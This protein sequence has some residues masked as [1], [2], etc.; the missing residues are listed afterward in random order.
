MTG[1]LRPILRGSCF[2]LAAILLAPVTAAAAE[3]D[4]DYDAATLTR[5]PLPFPSGTVATTF[6]SWTGTAFPYGMGTFRVGTTGEYSLAVSGI[7]G[8]V[9]IFVI[10][11]PFAPD[12]AAD[13]VTPLENVLAGTQAPATIPSIVLEAGV[14]Y[15]WLVVV[16]SGS[17]SGTVAIEGGCVEVGDITCTPVPTMTPWSLLV[18][19]L[20]LPFAARA[21]LRRQAEPGLP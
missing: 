6:T 10:E 21:A 19:F 1:L 20:C 11:G 17:G 8:G 4:F 3:V 16:S 7:A 18:L 13:P 5:F 12:A 2:I 9:G 14:D 15:T